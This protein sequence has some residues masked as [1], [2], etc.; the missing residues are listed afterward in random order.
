MERE[1]GGERHRKRK[2]YIYIYTRNIYKQTD[3]VF[4]WMSVGKL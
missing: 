1:K 2:R 3:K 4:V